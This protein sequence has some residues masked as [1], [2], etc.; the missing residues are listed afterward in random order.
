MV[1]LPGFKSKNRTIVVATEKDVGP[2]ELVYQRVL[3]A[4]HTTWPYS[5]LEFRLAECID[6]HS[7]V[8]WIPH[9]RIYTWGIGFTPIED[10]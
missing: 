4:K 10:L 8:I 3:Q 1:L 9:A 7:S 5:D 2:G 6:N